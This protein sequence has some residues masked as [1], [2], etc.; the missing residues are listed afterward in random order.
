M[1]QQDSLETIPSTSQEAPSTASANRHGGY[2]S[3]GEILSWLPH[4]ATPWQQDSAIRANYKFPET[5][6]SRQPNPMRTPQTKAD[7][8]SDFSLQKPLYHGKSLVQPDSIYRPEYAVY[9]QGVAGDPIPYN[10]ANDNLI[11]SI[12]LG[13]FILAAVAIAE[14]GNFIQ[15][16]FKNFFHQQREGTTIVTET[17]N[18]LRFQFFLMLQASLLFAL[19]FFFYSKTIGTETTGLPQYAVIGIFTGILSSYFLVKAILHTLIGWVF[20]DNKK[21]EQKMKTELFLAGTQGIALFPVVMLHAYFS[22]PIDNT[23]FYTAF[24]IILAKILSFYKTY[25]IFF[26][27]NGAFVQSFLYFC[28]FEMMPLGALWGVLVFTDNYLKVNY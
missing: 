1:T 20:F 24:V 21:I 2:H 10:I 6:W 25:I 8:A 19:I 23:V 5:D 9:H 18:E 26:K 22:F 3:P 12:L 27:R 28:A 13:C 16:Q 14:S 15:R 7:S 17:S 11:T 4:N